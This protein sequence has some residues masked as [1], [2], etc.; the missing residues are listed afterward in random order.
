[1]RVPPH[2]LSPKFF[3]YSGNF[4]YNAGMQECGRCGSEKPDESFTVNRARESGLAA[5]CRECMREYRL[6]R[7]ATREPGWVRKTSDMQA[8]QREYRKKN[9]EKYREYEKRRPTLVKRARW[10]VKE[11]VKTG[12][13]VRW[14]CFLCGEV[15][16]AHHPAYDLPLAV[17]W[18]CKTHHREAHRLTK[19]LE[20]PMAKCEKVPQRVKPTVRSAAATA[21]QGSHS[22][23]AAPATVLTSKVGGSAPTDRSKKK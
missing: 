14:P 9:R 20:N 15:A 21:K 6:E 18:L 12:K 19:E 7:G 16:D 23:K 17:T 1:M 3:V 8:Y 11:A 2:F 13:M 5:W 4:L 22:K 10:T